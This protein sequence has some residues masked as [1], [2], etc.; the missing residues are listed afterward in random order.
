MTKDC[1]HHWLLNITASAP[2]VMCNKCYTQF[3]PVAQQLSYHG[4]VPE[5]FKA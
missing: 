2:T 3:K 1:K 4:I 5:K